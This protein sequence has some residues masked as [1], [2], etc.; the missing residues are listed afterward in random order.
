M[1]T[2]PVR[3]AMCRAAARPNGA[4]RGPAAANVALR[5]PDSRGERR[6]R[7]VEVRGP[8]EAGAASGARRGRV[9]EALSAIAIPMVAATVLT[10]A[11]ATTLA[12]LPDTRL[13]S[14]ALARNG[15]LAF[16]SMGSGPCRNPRNSPAGSV[17]CAAVGGVV[18]V[19]DSG[20]SLSVTRVPPGGWSRRR[21][22]SRRRTRNVSL[23]WRR[24]VKR[25]RSLCAA[26]GVGVG[27]A[28]RQSSARVRS[29]EIA[30]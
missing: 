8:S 28:W 15:R 14:R 6:R 20:A 22:S 5:E 30:G 2:G 3:T 4:I 17:R 29:G 12:G 24:R 18:N 19:G 7:A 21:D 11:R 23:R 9:G 16:G 26:L 13:G 27:S 10:S 25:L 1:L